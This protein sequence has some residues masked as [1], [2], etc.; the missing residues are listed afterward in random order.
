[1]SLI[2]VSPNFYGASRPL[3]TKPPCMDRK[4]RYGEAFLY[5]RLEKGDRKLANGERPM[6]KG[7]EKA[8]NSKQ[9]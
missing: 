2:A 9:N 6:A 3:Y 4:I 5:G 7:R 8:E 1:M